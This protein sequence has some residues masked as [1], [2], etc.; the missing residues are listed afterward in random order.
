MLGKRKTWTGLILVFLLIC[1][2]NPGYSHR[3]IVGNWVVVEEHMKFNVRVLVFQPDNTFTAYTSDF[4]PMRLTGRYYVDLFKEPALI[5]IEINGSE[6]RNEGYLQMLN[7][8]KMIL[9]TN[10]PLPPEPLYGSGQTIISK[11]PVSPDR[12]VYTITL[13]RMK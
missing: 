5:D 10:A 1:L 12:G 4:Q 2:G 11:R 8:N 3:G 9:Y 7:S 6:Y 13:R